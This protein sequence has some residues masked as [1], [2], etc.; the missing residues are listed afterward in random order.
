[1]IAENRWRAS[2]HGLDAELVDLARDRPRPAR[3]AVR[4]LIELAGPAADRLGC[5]EELAGVE[6]ILERGPGADEQRRA[7]EGSE[8]SLLAVARWLAETT[9]EDL[10]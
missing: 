6:R 10:G 5:T 8:G 2:R 1:M 9:V 4:E 7:Y 3:E